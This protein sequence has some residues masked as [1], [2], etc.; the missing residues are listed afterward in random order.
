MSEYYIKITATAKNDL[1]EIAKYISKELLESKVAKQVIYN[2]DNKI[3]SLETM[4]LRN[5]LVND[6]R[7]ALQGIRKMLIDNYIVFYIVDEQQ[8]IVL[9]TRILYSRRDRLD[10]L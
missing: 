1:Y 3:L 7:L 9:V 4:P 8:K 5:G 10:I 2:I 6:G